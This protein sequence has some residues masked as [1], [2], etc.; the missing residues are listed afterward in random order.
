MT[1]AER[2]AKMRSLYL[3]WYDGAKSEYYLQMAAYCTR[4]IA[5]VG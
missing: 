4:R 1:E 5:E 3:H 2:L